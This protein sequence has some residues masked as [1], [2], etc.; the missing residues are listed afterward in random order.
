[1]F[2]PICLLYYSR[3]LHGYIASAS[4]IIKAFSSKRNRKKIFFF[5][6]G[7]FILVVFTHCTFKVTGN[8]LSSVLHVKWWSSIAASVNVIYVFS[9][10]GLQ[11]TVAPAKGCRMYPLLLELVSNALESIHW[12]FRLPCLTTLICYCNISIR[13]CLSFCVYCNKERMVCKIFNMGSS[14]KVDSKN[15][16]SSSRS[17]VLVSSPPHVDFRNINVSN[18]RTLMS[19]TLRL[20]LGL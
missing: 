12:A 1:M 17:A 4:V 10:V 14:Q 7:F 2:F 16:D 15:F 5:F 6:L 18:V 3:V 8:R 19:R 9:A 13:T 20:R 11:L